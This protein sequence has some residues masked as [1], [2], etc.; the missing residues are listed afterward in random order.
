MRHPEKSQSS[1]FTHDNYFLLKKN[2]ILPF[3][4]FVMLLPS[5]HVGYSHSIAPQVPVP[6]LEDIPSSHAS[7]QPPPPHTPRTFPD[8]RAPA[9]LTRL[10]PALHS[11]PRYARQVFP[12]FTLEKRAQKRSEE[13][14]YYDPMTTAVCLKKTSTIMFLFLPCQPVVMLKSAHIWEKSFLESNLQLVSPTPPFFFFPSYLPDLT[15]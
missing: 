8:S 7:C 10:H 3:P 5:K 15:S 11:F 14:K 1:V 6:S 12:N 2:Q 4:S 9:E 13:G